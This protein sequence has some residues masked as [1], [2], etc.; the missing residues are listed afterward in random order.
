MIRVGLL[1]LFIALTGLA[2]GQELKIER[3]QK[4]VEEQGKRYYLHTVRPG[5]TLFSICKL[6]G[7]DMQLVRDGNGLIDNVLSVNVV[8]KIP[9]VEPYRPL[10]DKFYYHRM[11]PKETL[12]SL[13]RKFGVRM[14]RILKDNPEYE[15]GRPIATG[16]IVRLALKQINRD[17]LNAELEWE[18]RQM[19]LQQETKEPL[20]KQI[21]TI[22]VKPREEVDDVV[23]QVGDTVY[24]FIENSFPPTKELRVALLLPFY[25]D[26]N[27]LPVE[28]EI[29]VDSVGVN[30]NDERFRLH[31]K[32][33]QFVQFYEGFL[34]A[35]DS[36]K[37]EGYTIHLNVYDTEK[38]VDKMEQI[39]TDLN[40]F[41]PQLIVGP[42]YANVF[43]A[44]AKRLVNKSVP[45]VYPLSTRVEG[46]ECFPNLIQVNSSVA[47]LL[48][49]MARWIGEQDQAS[50]VLAIDTKLIA[51]SA[52]EEQQLVALTREY[53][54]GKPF[55]TITWQGNMV[56]DSL[57]EQFDPEQENIVLLPSVNQAV[58][59]QVLPV[60]TALAGQYK[61]TLLGF[62][63]WLKFSALDDETFFKLNVKL[64]MNSYVDYQTEAAKDFSAKHRAYFYSEPTYLSNRAFDIGM[65]FIPRI[66]ANWGTWRN[67]LLQEG[68]EGLF[69]RFKF[70]ELQPG[71]GIENQ[72]FFL[73]HFTSDYEIRVTP[74]E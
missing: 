25:L 41:A 72:A 23:A 53:A 8:L 64:F 11:K 32:S 70:K 30:V 20:G 37:R 38:R 69:T 43:E 40:Y 21:E 67:N 45:M 29:Q 19:Q 24:P 65:F 60:L 56:L 39:A 50:R 62:P 55:S 10:D 31:G 1:V 16:S 27:K 58:A 4:L 33:E 12:Y 22:P 51:R 3:S 15:E 17:V 6:Y 36:L 71:G 68:G 7:V 74:V 28:G 18:K 61:I 44:L 47:V 34:L 73:V 54:V 46:L 5:E 35:L 66:A 14:K 63:E 13:S 59:S 42:V 57:K 9:Y 2:E 52:E 26:E 48:E 49:R